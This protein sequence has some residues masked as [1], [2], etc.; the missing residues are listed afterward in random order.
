LP[1]ENTDMKT[2]VYSKEKLESKGY[3]IPA[4]KISE[5]PVNG[6]TGRPYGTNSIRYWIWWHGLSEHDKGVISDL[7]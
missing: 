6:K 2:L 1:K 3:K 5:R 7:I 4:T